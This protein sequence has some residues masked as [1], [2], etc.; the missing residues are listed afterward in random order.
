MLNALR[1]VDGVPP[2]LFAERTGLAATTIDQRLR[3]AQSQGLLET[4]S[5][6]SGP[7]G[8]AGSFSTT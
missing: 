8:A 4:T 7:R 1:L 2:T 5:S 6:A 3:S